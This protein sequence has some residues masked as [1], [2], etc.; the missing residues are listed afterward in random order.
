MG[1]NTLSCWTDFFMSDGEKPNRSREREFINGL[2]S[3]EKLSVCWK[4][5]GAFFE[6]IKNRTMC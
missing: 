4:K 3:K 1:G 5:D 2:K 6:F